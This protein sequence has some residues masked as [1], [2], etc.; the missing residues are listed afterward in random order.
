[1]LN[2]A[3]L[4]KQ[5]YARLLEQPHMVALREKCVVQIQALCTPD[6]IV[7][8]MLNDTDPVPTFH[9][10]TALQGAIG[11]RFVTYY[12]KRPW[13]KVAYIRF[14]D[15]YSVV[16]NADEALNS[17]RLA[18]RYLAGLLEQPHM[19]ALKEKCTAQIRA[20]FTPDK[21]V[22]VML[23]DTDPVPNKFEMA[24]LQGAIG[25][26]YT[27]YYPKRAW[28]KVAYIEFND[29]NYSV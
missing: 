22:Y 18:K 5:H 10:M 28:R 7:N 29:N 17:E 19:V 25:W 20:L 3:E 21:L 1:M 12:P 9:E 26:R 8:V 13:R 2:T 14:S 23:D 11:W 6:K 16:Q 4:T 27:N 24:A 15:Q